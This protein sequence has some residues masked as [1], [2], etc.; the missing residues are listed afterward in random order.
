MQTLTST[1]D[2]DVGYKVEEDPDENGSVT[3]NTSKAT[4]DVCGRNGGRRTSRCRSGSNIRS[5]NQPKVRGFL[6][7]N[8][9]RTKHTDNLL[10]RLNPKNA[11]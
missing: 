8:R 4:A 7:S 9:S 10:K 1:A 6:C 3:S 11:T 5:R 2:V